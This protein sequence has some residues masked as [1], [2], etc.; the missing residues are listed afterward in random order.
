MLELLATIRLILR[1]LYFVLVAKKLVYN[2][3][4]EHSDSFRQF[5]FLETRGDT[6]KLSK[7]DIRFEPLFF[8]R[9]CVREQIF[10]RK[11]A[12]I[13]LYVTTRF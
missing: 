6:A 13:I 7:N 2:E 9:C 3:K 11:V 4:E 10:N 1:K 8:C 5:T 12:V